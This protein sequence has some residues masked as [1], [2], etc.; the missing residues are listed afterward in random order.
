[1]PKTKRGQNEKQPGQTP[2]RKRPGTHNS[3]PAS[4]PPKLGSHNYTKKKVKGKLY[5]SKK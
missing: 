2:A 1:M 4:A 5:G 3:R